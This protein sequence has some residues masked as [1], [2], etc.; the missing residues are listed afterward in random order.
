MTRKQHIENMIMIVM[1]HKRDTWL[2]NLSKL[3]RLV[4]PKN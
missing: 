1:G 3:T 4:R 2:A